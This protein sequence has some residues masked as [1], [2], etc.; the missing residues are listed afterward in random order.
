MKESYFTPSFIQKW[1]KNLKNKRF[2]FAFENSALL[3]IDLQKYFLK[4]D[5]DAYV[6]SSEYIIEKLIKIARIYREKKLEIILTRHIDDEIKHPLMKKWWESPIKKE[7]PQSE[8]LEELKEFGDYGILIEKNY[9][10]AFKETGLYQILKG[11]GIERVLIG[12]VL[13]NCCCETTARS[14]FMNNFEV[15]F[16]FDG[17]ATYKKEFHEGSILNISYAFGTVIFCKDVF[18]IE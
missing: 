6:P 5:G 8:L 3:L 17:T 2:D 4:K 13:T 7:N 9:Y 10:D 12:G 11:R 1:E 16:L 18:Q 15:F 14:A